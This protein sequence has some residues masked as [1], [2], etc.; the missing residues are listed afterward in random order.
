[1]LILKVLEVVTLPIIVMVFTVISIMV[2][3]PEKKEKNN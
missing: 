3:T 1:M 2:W